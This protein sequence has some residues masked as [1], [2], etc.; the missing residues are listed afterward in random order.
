MSAVYVQ[1]VGLFSLHETHV[2]LS[3]SGHK[4]E[5]EIGARKLR[6]LKLQHG[7]L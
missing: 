3:I 2:K 5:A 4:N 6:Y 1:M 7:K